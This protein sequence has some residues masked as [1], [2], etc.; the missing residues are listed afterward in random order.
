MKFECKAKIKDFSV[1]FG[2]KK[3]K[4]LLEIDGDFSG[5]YDEWKDLD[6]KIT[7]NKHSEHRSLD[8]NALCWKLC[9]EIANVLRT[10][11]DEIYIELLKR[12]GQSD[13]MSVRSDVNVKPY[14]KYFE[15]AGQ[16]KVN[17]KL[18]THYKVF[19]GSSEY[20]TREMSILLDG[21]VSEAK[22]LNIPILTKSELELMKSEWG[23]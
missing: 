23:R 1:S 9:T 5:I 13:I 12:Y 11:K 14:F 7:I 21:I 19:K 6:L 15:E 8:A 17:G 2:N 3:Q 18:F 16:G 20:D 4:L 22:E 10:S